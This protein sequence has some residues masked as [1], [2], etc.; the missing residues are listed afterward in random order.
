MKN[1]VIIPCYNES[2]R[3]PLDEYSVFL[4]TNTDC[5]LIFVNDGSTDD[6]LSILQ[7]LQISFPEAVQIITLEQNAGKAAAVRAGMLACHDASFEKVGYL[8]A[9]LATSLEEWRAIANNV[10]GDIVFAFGSRI[11]KID[12]YISRKKYR[13]YS[14]RV[15]ATFISEA[16]GIAVYDTQCGCKVFSAGLVKP[17]FEDAFISKWLFDVEIFFRL[18]NRHG[19]P[20]MSKIC[21]EIPLKRWHDVDESKVKFTYFFK[22][23]IDL[24][25]IAKKYRNAA[26]SIL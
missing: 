18:K 15:I 22:L 2:S 16:L 20:E 5:K 8:D 17:L 26:K 6:T 7:H 12:N 11:S 13:H 21:R 3:L 19:G 23:W 4:L 1:A 24:F 25:L 10:S 14:G 9:D